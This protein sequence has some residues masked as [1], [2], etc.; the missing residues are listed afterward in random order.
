MGGRTGLS[1]WPM[2]KRALPSGVGSGL[3]PPHPTRHR[4]TPP[5]APGN[6]APWLEEAGIVYSQGG[7]QAC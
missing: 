7:G 5:L 3:F 4:Y 6:A 1:L 2:G